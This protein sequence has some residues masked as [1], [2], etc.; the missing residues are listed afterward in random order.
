M[1][2][3]QAKH[4]IFIKVKDKIMAIKLKEINK[5]YSEFN[6]FDYLT[7]ISK[8]LPWKAGNNGFQETGQVALDILLKHF[9]VEMLKIEDIFESEDMI[10]PQNGIRIL[11]TSSQ[12]FETSKSLREIN[13]DK[14]TESVNPLITKNE[15]KAG[16]T[17]YEI[18]GIKNKLEN[19]KSFKY[20]ELEICLKILIR[21]HPERF[22]TERENI[23]CLHQWLIDEDEQI[24]GL[25]SL[26]GLYK[27]MKSNINQHH[28][29]DLLKQSI[30]NM[31]QSHNDNDLESNK[32]IN[33]EIIER[34]CVLLNEIEWKRDG[35]VG[36]VPDILFRSNNVLNEMSLVFTENNKKDEN[37]EIYKFG[38]YEFHFDDEKGQCG[39]DCFIDCSNVSKNI[40]FGFKEF[41]KADPKFLHQEKLW[42]EDVTFNASER[43]FIGQVFYE[44]GL[45][46]H[47]YSNETFDSTR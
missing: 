18:N 24:M 6:Q 40:E 37:E 41:G 35:S 45:V 19:I 25:I 17:E 1:S 46:E 32:D 27:Q 20:E 7:L 21:L 47:K 28:S 44:G 34:V 14:E 38:N 11:E 2:Q 8:F 42:F 29:Y 26:Q 43:K 12:I 4:N 16:F 22:F 30:T 10:N 23:S 13:L 33:Y 31:F 3:K 5:I 9:P 36:D 39:Q 15:L